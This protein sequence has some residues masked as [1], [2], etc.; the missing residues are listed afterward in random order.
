MNSKPFVTEPGQWQALLSEV[1]GAW[2]IETRDLCGKPCKFFVGDF[3]GSELVLLAFSIPTALEIGMKVVT[4]HECGWCCCH[5]RPAFE[6]TA[7]TIPEGV[8]GRIVGLG[9]HLCANLRHCARGVVMVE[10]DPETTP[11]RHRWVL[12]LPP[13]PL[14]V[15]TEAQSEAIT[16]GGLFV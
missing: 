8:T 3:D 12:G 10:T 4:N 2:R 9:L 6:I 14:Q 5:S 1:F 7:H 11:G 13:V 16:Y 15:I